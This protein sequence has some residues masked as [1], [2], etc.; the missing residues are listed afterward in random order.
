MARVDEPHQCVRPAVRF[1]HRVPQHAVVAPAVRSAEGVDRHH[2]DE[3]DAEIHQIV[4]LLDRRV[5]SAARSERA[6]VQFVDHPAL[7][8]GA[9]PVVVGPCVGIGPPELRAGMHTV[10]LARGT[11]IGQ[12]R[13]VVVENEPVA[14]IRSGVD[15]GTP[16]AVVR[17]GHLVQRAVHVDT[18][19]LGNAAPTPRT[20]PSS[21]LQKRH[22][23]L[24]EQLGG[25]DPAAE[26]CAGDAV[27]PLAVRQRDSGVAP[28][29]LGQQHRM[30]AHR[31]QHVVAAQKR[32]Q[33]VGGRA[34]GP[35]RRVAA[36]GEARRAVPPQTQAPPPRPESSD[37][38]TPRALHSGRV[39]HRT[40]IVRIDQAVLPQ[41]GALID[42]RNTGRG[43]CDQF[44]AK[45]VA[46]R[47]QVEPGHQR[48]HLGADRAVQHGV[49]PRVYRSLEFFVR[50]VPGGVQRGLADRLLGVG[51]QP[52]P[53]RWVDRAVHGPHAE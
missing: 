3:V 35:H 1:V 45:G 38:A 24:R 51:V 28:A 32:H 44:L 37:G 49:E 40:P 10:G 16:P 8:R 5:E 53:Q 31:G 22:R 17:R 29:G 43:E 7:D 39:V 42:V 12:H 20:Q 11:R 6:D 48:R 47:M 30:P 25:Q 19:P 27:G 2:F 33:V 21:A 14:R 26:S 41:F 15:L 9:R 23:Q 36:V 50:V 52:L 18:N 46:A 13:R 34:L 4:Q